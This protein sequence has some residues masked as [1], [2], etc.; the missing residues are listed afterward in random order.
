M[1]LQDSLNKLLQ[2]RLKSIGGPYTAFHIRNTDYK[3]D[4]R[5]FVTRETKNI[6][7]PIF[8]AT[9]SFPTLI[10]CERIIGEDRAFSFTSLPPMDDKPLHAMLENSP[11]NN[12][13]AI[14]DL[15]MLALA[16]RLFIMPL[17][18]NPAG[19]CYSGFSI[20][21]QKLFETKSIMEGLINGYSNLG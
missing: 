17:V 15:C 4:Y 3:T 2:Q 6:P 18:N 9:D 10:E 16:E 7:G 13:D 20:L 21:A 5:D 14:L 19:E 8:I 11:I 12:R 1:Y